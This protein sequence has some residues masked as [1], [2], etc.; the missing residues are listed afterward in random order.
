MDE[1]NA[2]LQKEKDSIEREKSLE[3]KLK[4]QEIIN[5]SKDEISKKNR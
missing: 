2:Q 4:E 5:R 3:A 1:F